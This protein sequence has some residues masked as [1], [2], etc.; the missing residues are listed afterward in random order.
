MNLK[1]SA[2]TIKA[3]MLL[4]CVEVIEQVKIFKDV[5]EGFYK[6]FNSII[7]DINHNNDKVLYRLI[8]L[9]EDYNINKYYFSQIDVKHRFENMIR[10]CQKV[11]DTIVLNELL[12]EDVETIKR[13]IEEMAC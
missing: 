11:E 7:K 6:K 13:E 3:L 5:E 10:K 1:L 9:R 2:R 4:E 8:D 12:R